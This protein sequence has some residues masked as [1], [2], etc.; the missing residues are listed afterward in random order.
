MYVYLWSQGAPF[1]RWGV[2][3]GPTAPMQ[4]VRGDQNR[5]QLITSSIDWRPKELHS[6]LFT[7]GFEIW[8]I[9][10]HHKEQ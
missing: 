7:R 6:A 4:I 1:W 5:R 2:K 10:H 3:N 9:P 8:Q